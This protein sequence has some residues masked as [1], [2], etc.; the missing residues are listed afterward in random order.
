MDHRTKHLL[1]RLQECEALQLEAARAEFGDA[2]DGALRAG[3]AEKVTVPSGLSTTD[4]SLRAPDAV[5]LFELRLTAA[6]RAALR[7]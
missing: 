4:A 6:G 7:F 2:V 1:S 5:L 3:L